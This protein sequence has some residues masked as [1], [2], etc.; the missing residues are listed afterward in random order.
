MGKAIK[1]KEL[2]NSVGYAI[3]VSHAR[4]RRF[5]FLVP[6]RPNEII[7]TD[8]VWVGVD[9]SRLRPMAM[10]DQWTAQNGR[11]RHTGE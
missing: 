2:G 6:H 8:R 7:L 1:T 9:V 10:T 5:P 4:K 3:S 11:L